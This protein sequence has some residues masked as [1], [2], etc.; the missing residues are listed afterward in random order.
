MASFNEI[1]VRQNGKD[2]LIQAS[3]F[4]VIRTKLVEAFGTGGYILEQDPQ[5][6]V[7]SGEITY[8]AVA[9]KPLIPLEGDGGPVTLSNTPF[10]TTH[11]FFGGKEIILLGSSD[12]NTVT[13]E[14]NDIDEGIIS[15]GKIVLTKYDQVIL[16][17]NANLKRFIR[18]E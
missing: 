13:L 4:N 16:I 11:G 7:A 14:V 6:V 9:F 2:H 10:G 12:T 3:W 1:P 18:K 15:N 5:T 17:Y 8:D